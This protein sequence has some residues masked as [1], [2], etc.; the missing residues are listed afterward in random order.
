MTWR[1]GDVRVC[2]GT[3][4]YPDMKGFYVEQYLYAQQDHLHWVI[5]AWDEK[6][7]GMLT[8]PFD[9]IDDAER[10]IRHYRFTYGRW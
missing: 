5:P 3:D 8:G 1:L 6:G 10:A 9:T 2:S 4:Y 7:C